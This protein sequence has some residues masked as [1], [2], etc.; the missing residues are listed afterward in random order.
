MAKSEDDNAEAGWRGDDSANDVPADEP[1]DE[2]NGID[3]LDVGTSADERSRFS[4][5]WLVAA[6][7][8]LLTAACLWLYGYADGAFVAAALGIL[9]WFINVKAQLRRKDSHRDTGARS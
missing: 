5:L 6:C 9:A 1:G 2:A 7:L 4:Y 3:H 8:C